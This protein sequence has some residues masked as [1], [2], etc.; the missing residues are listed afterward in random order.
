VAEDGDL[1]EGGSRAFRVAAPPD[2]D[3][4]QGRFLAAIQVASG[5]PPAGNAE[6][7]R[8]TGNVDGLAV[9]DV[10]AV[11][12]KEPKGAAVPSF[13]YT[14]AGT[15]KRT[16]VLLDMGGGCNAEIKKSGDATTVTVSPGNKYPAKDGMV[17]ITE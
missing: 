2:G 8:P 5:G 13:S 16:H 6:R 1:P 7:I 9:G 17:R 4:A 3:P 11:F 12:S 14:V 10:V 15:G